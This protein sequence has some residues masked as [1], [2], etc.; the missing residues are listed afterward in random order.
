MPFVERGDL[1]EDFSGQHDGQNIMVK[2]RCS[3]G[4]Y[5][6]VVRGTN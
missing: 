3:I 5:L 1:I 6:V 4:G 2:S